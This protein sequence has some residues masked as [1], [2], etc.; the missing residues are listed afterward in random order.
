MTCS[1][2]RP[3]A[4][5][6][7]DTLESELAG[8]GE[9]TVSGGRAKNEAKRLPSTLILAVAI[10]KA[11]IAETRPHYWIP[12]QYWWRRWREDRS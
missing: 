11:G 6:A 8:V 10:G 7:D 12:H 5:L 9:E 3:C 1:T 4:I 2:V